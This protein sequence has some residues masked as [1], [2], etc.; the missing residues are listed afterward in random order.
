MRRFV[1][2][3][4][5]R[6]R[7]SKG[8]RPGRSAR[9][10]LRLA[11]LAGTSG[12]RRVANMGAFAWLLTA[13]LCS[14]CGPL[15][16]NP[17]PAGQA[18]Q[19]ELN[20][21]IVATERGRRG[22]RLV[23]I[24]EG[25]ERLAELTRS[26]TVAV[27][28]NS[29]SW[30][31]DGRFVVF[32]SSRG[33]DSLLRTSLWVIAARPDARPRRLTYGDAVD[34]DPVWTADGRGVVF[35]SN[36]NGSFD[37]WRLHVAIDQ[38]GVPAIRGEPTRLT[39]APGHE[40]APSVSPD[41]QRVVYMAVDTDKTSRLWV[42]QE[43]KNQPITAGPADYTPAFSPDGTTIAFAAPSQREPSDQAAHCATA[44]ADLYL[45]DTDGNNRR[46]LLREPLSDQTGPVWSF[47]GRFVFATSVYRSVKTCDSLLSS[48][49][50]VDL[51]ESPPVMRALHDPA[52]V[53]P[54]T[55]PAVDRAALD[56]VRLRRN[57][58][59]KDALRRA[60]IQELI[61]A[62][63]DQRRAGDRQGQE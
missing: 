11:F 18:G 28:D 26:T 35:A 27:R 45:I 38:Y 34:R 15:D 32:A 25:G 41:G 4:R 62:S 53:E 12:T 7:R 16:N 49:T 56:A 21:H 1:H 48:I 43:A 6:P 20:A 23:F 54:R 36:R 33:R 31:P 42:W 9:Y 29:P 37:L 50:F 52:A 59:Y 3:E 5:R 57:R 22:G 19:P 14:A 40:L 8:R 2:G 60:V 44:D 61:R 51:R 10:E 63:S 30:S 13:W 39:R 46:L 55:G 24:A 47:D 58:L 17:R